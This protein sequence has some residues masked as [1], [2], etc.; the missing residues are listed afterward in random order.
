MAAL[1]L[2]QLG[3]GSLSAGFSM[4]QIRV[5][6]VKAVSG[7]NSD[8]VMVFSLGAHAPKSNAAIDTTISDFFMVRISFAFA[9]IFA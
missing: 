1:E 5:F 9:I 4:H 6:F 2:M 8:T 7:M 3:N